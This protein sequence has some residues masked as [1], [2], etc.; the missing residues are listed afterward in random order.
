MSIVTL[1]K[2]VGGKEKAL[3][4]GNPTPREMLVQHFQLP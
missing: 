2:S 4:L 3:A 1:D